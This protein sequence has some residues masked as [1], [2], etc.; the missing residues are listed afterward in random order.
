MRRFQEVVDECGLQEVEFSGPLFTWKRGSTFERLDRCFINQDAA[1]LFPLFHEA[2]VDVGASDHILLVLL[3]EG[4]HGGRFRAGRA[5]R[6]FQFEAL[7]TKEQ[8]CGNVVKENWSGNGGLLDVTDRL[9]FVSRALQQW[10]ATTIGHIPKKNEELTKWPFDSCDDGVQVK[11]KEVVSELNK[12]LELEES[13]WKQRS[14]VSWLREGDQNTKFFHS[15]AK[16]RGR[17]NCIQGITNSEG[18]WQDSEEGIQHAFLA[19]FP[20]LFTSEGHNHMELVLDAVPMRVTDEMNQRLSKPFTRIDIETALKHMSPDKSPGEDGFPTRFYQTYWDVIGDEISSTC[21]KVLNEG[22]GVAR[23]NHTLLALIPKVDNPQVVTDFRPISLCNVLYKLISKTVVNRM[24]SLLPEVISSYQ[25][26]FVPGRSIHDNVITAFE[27]VHSIR[28]R[29]TG[30]DPYC[31]LKHDI[32]KAYDRVEWV[33]LQNIILR[34]GFNERWVA[35]VMRCVKSVWFSILWNGTAV[36]RITPTRG[37]L[38]GDP[39]SPYLFL[40]CSEGLTGLFQKA[41]REGL[42]HG[43]KVCEGVP[44]I[45]HLLFTD[46]SLLFG[47]ADI[48]EATQLKQSLLLYESAAGQKINFQK[49]AISFGPGLP[50]AQ[51]LPIIQML[52]VP[53]VPFHERY[54]G[55]PIVAGRN[56]K[57]MFKKIHERLD[58]HLKGWQSKLLSKAGKTVLI[59]VVAQAIPSY[60]MSVFR[61]SK[62]VCRTYQSKIGKYWWGNGGKKRGIH[63]C[64]WQVLYKNKLAGGLG[65]RDIE[66]FTQALLAKTVW[67]IV[68]QTN[69]LVNC[70][71]QQK[72]AVN[73]NWAAVQVGSKDSFIWKSLMW[74]KE[75]LCAG[76]RRRIGNGDTTRIWEDKWLPSPWSFRV[77]TLRF[78]DS[79]TTVNQLMEKPGMWNVDFIKDKF[80]SVDVEKILSIPLCESSGGDVA[81]WHYTK[82]GY[83]TVKSGY[84]LGMELRQVDRGAECS[85]ENDVS[86]SNNVWSLIWGLGVPNKVKLFLWRACHAF[87]PC[88]ERLVRRKV[89]S[90][91]GCGRCGRPGETVLH[92]LWECP[93]VQKIWKGTWLSGFVKHWRESSFTDLLVHVADVGTQSELEFFG[94]LCW[95]IW[96]SRNDMLHGKEEVNPGQIVQRCVEWQG[97]LSTVLGHTTTIQGHQM[98][99]TGGL[100]GALSIPLPVPI[101]AEATEALALWNGLCYCK[102]LGLRRVKVF[103]DALNVLNGLTVPSW[104]LSDIGGI[105]DAIRLIKLFFDGATDAGRGC[106]GLGAVI[107]NNMG[108]LIGALSIPLP[109]LGLRRVKVFGDALN[110]LNGLTV[111]SWDLSDIGGILDAVRLIK[112]Y[113]PNDPA[114]YG[115]IQEQLKPSFDLLEDAGFEK[116]KKIIRAIDDMKEKGDKLLEKLNAIDKKLEEKLAELDHTFGKKGKVLEKEIK[117]LAE[118]RND[119]TEKKRSPRS[120]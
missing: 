42:I 72:Y 1:E 106:V 64:T 33:F 6:R 93:K 58:Y 15:Y 26:A 60:T 45:S 85:R 49:S 12:Y 55:L 110:V 84:W 35:L 76:I 78:L 73:G 24:K 89:C 39:L 38:Q 116:E 118:E 62:G 23:L 114:N 75:L 22:A 2:H 46:D 117:D 87:L 9:A 65:F 82:D 52:G 112:T 27:V 29:L 56:R 11:R 81:V 13:L 115:V 98:N 97:E 77:I 25:S 92:S 79:A 102:E 37:L 61:L 28:N 105:L 50:Q 70:I 100:I 113:D 80:L 111:P 36:G 101:K 54:L 86:N 95:W 17:K 10:N 4:P 21:L 3:A 108:G 119:L 63:W 32:S 68:F 18:V 103:G 74:G 67:R 99:N 43:A 51:K 30:D 19:Y 47:K 16:T 109:E 34:M 90:H 91:D 48:Q 40:L 59:K 7:W 20:M 96:K 31:V 69:S 66:C 120:L 94:L 41:D 88:V 8:D 5:K 14:R 104:D 71:L 53:V 44:A 83:Y 107:V 57:E